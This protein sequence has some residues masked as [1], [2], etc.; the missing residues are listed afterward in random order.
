MPDELFA[1][2]AVQRDLANLGAL[3]ECLRILR[4]QPPGN[5]Q[6]LSAV[7]IQEGIIGRRDVEVIE[8]VVGSGAV[9]DKRIARYQLLCMIG[10]GGMGAV[11]AVID[12]DSLE[13]C[14]LK[15]LPKELAED[16][17]IV[18]RFLREAETACTLRHPNIVGGLRAGED[19]GLHFFSM[20]FVDGS[21]VYDRLEAEGVLPEGESLRIV[22]G[23]SLGLLYAYV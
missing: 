14:A 21:T 18:T 13:F 11:Y 3:R 5:R 15:I 19:Q 9:R 20:E 6:P 17:D 8:S 12:V 7:M 1:R 16:P 4:D 22:R 23:T 2:A 10:E